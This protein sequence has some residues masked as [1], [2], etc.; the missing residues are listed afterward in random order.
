MKMRQKQE[1]EFTNMNDELQKLKSRN[2]ELDS[3]N[4]LLTQK[5]KNKNTEIEQLRKRVKE[6]ENSNS[7]NEQMAID[8]LNEKRKGL[9]NEE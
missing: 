1:R 2:Q 4:R 5:L 3:N 8:D 6:L 7:Q 9:I